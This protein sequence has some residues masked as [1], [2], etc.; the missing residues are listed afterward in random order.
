MFDEI[1][2]NP[3]AWSGDDLARLIG[4]IDDLLGLDLLG[5]TPDLSDDQRSLLTER[6]SARAAKDWPASDRLRDELLATGVRVRDTPTGQ[7]WEYA[8]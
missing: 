4:I 7:L 6:G 3:Q 1:E 2:A 5:T 8:G